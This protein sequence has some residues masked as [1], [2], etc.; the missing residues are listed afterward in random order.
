VPGRRVLIALKGGYNPA[1]EHSLIPPISYTGTS[2]IPF[3]NYFE[4]SPPA[5]NTITATQKKFQSFNLFFHQKQ[6]A[7]CDADHCFFT[8]AWVICRFVAA[9]SAQKKLQIQD[10]R[11]TETKET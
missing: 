4:I 3:I 6:T 5:P 10:Q 2:K 9:S 1:V 11:K 7:R 8:P